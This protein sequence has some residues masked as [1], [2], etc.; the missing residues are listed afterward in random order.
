MGDHVVQ[1]AGDASALGAHPLFGDQPLLS[2]GTFGTFGQVGDV[3]AASSEVVAD[4]EL[5]LT[6]SVD[7]DIGAL[8]DSVSATG[9]RLVQEALTNIRRHAGPVDMVS[10]DI[11]V[12]DDRLVVEI[13]DNGRGAGARPSQDGF[14]IVGM[15]ER[16][17]TLGGTV[18]AGPRP[19]GGWRVR[20]TLPLGQPHDLPVAR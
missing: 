13:A 15:R 4:D 16:V 14:G 12:D 5:P 7:G 1:V 11:R 8:P 2:F 18:D 3:L 9:Y 20:S 19:G 10:V 17:A 6:I